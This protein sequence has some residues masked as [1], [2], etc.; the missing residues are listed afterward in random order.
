MA[1]KEHFQT[2]ITKIALKFKEELVGKVKWILD[3]Q[4]WQENLDHDDT[5]AEEFGR[6]FDSPEVKNEDLGFKPDTEDGYVNM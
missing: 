5:F 6:V 3:P 1:N 2:F 4:E